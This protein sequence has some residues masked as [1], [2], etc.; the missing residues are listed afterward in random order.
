M[1]CHCTGTDCISQIKDFRLF[2]STTKDG[3]TAK[4][5]VIYQEKREHVPAIIIIDL[6]NV[7]NG[8]YV[9]NI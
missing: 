1:F 7:I 2:I 5:N 6:K 3:V 9:V 8:R 4:T